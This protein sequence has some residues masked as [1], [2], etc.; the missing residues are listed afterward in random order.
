MT[1]CAFCLIR[2]VAALVAAAGLLLGSCSASASARGLAA[3]ESS[4]QASSRAVTKFLVVVEENQSLGQTKVDMPYAFSLAQRYGYA[5]NYHAISHPSLPNYLA[6]VSGQTHG[7]AD[8]GT[9]GAHRL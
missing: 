8:D 9:P 5:T 2:L 3:P 1:A 4:G 7:V 6:I